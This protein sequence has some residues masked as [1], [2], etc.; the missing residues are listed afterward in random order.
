MALLNKELK[1]STTL[2]ATKEPEKPKV[3]KLENMDKVP[4]WVVKPLN[5]ELK[6]VSERTNPG[7]IIFNSA[8]LFRMVK[9]E[10]EQRYPDHLKSLD[11]E[12]FQRCGLIDNV[13][14]GQS[15]YVLAFI[16]LDSHDPDKA[17]R[18][19]EFVVDFVRQ[20]FNNILVEP[21]KPRSLWE[22]LT[23]WWKRVTM[24]KRPGMM[25]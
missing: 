23:A 10:F 17:A 22:R 11:L 12:D 25:P 1:I 21:K 6:N 15:R 19:F 3:Y 5:L 2:A 18:L 4:E 24:P 20:V 7:S 13:L 16:D 9:S 8:K 14:L